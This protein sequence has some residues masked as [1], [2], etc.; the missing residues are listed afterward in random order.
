M[1]KKPT[2]K[3]DWF[4]LEKYNFLSTYTA[5]DWCKQL[6]TRRYLMFCLESGIYKARKSDDFDNLY[7]ELSKNPNLHAEKSDYTTETYNTYQ[8]HAVRGKP[9][10][11]LFQ[12]SISPLVYEDAFSALQNT[13]KDLI[14]PTGKILKLTRSEYERFIPLDYFHYIAPDNIPNNVINVRVE[15]DA[16]D[17]V[18]IADFKTHITEARKIYRS[19]EGAK[20][21]NNKTIINNLYIHRILPCIDLRIWAKKTDSDIKNHIYGDWLFP[22]DD[23]TDLSEKM[24]KTVIP[25]AKRSIEFS[26]IQTLG[27]L[28]EE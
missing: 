7:S 3:P 20:I 9:Y 19:N 12:R 27:N 26:F 28:T 16:P 15:L 25:L 5:E 17:S 24:R 11:S 22:E 6:W 10:E 1:G 14:A 8:Q 21:K 4:D 18:L 13:P 23:S 2:E